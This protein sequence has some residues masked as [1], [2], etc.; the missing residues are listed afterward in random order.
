MRQRKLLKNAGQQV[1]ETGDSD[2]YLQ[3]F[4]FY[5]Q[6][7]LHWWYVKTP[8][9]NLRRLGRL[10]VIA[11]DN[12]SISLLFKNFFVPW[13]RDK[14]ITGYFFGFLIKILYL[15]IASVIYL[16]TMLIYTTFILIWLILPI[17]TIV[18]IVTSIFK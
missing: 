1:I 17:I 8:I 15:P 16:A 6:D 4:I 7:F 9:R 10:S 13:H 14:T 18:F 3:I 12:L 5:I 2:S 11:D